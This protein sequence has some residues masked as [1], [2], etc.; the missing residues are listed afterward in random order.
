MNDAER[1]KLFLMNDAGLMYGFGCS[2]VAQPSSVE[3]TARSVPDSTN[4]LAQQTE[5]EKHK[6]SIRTYHI[7]PREVPKASW[8]RTHLTR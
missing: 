5:P 3:P 7:L 4:Q 6:G 1:Q 2:H 8:G